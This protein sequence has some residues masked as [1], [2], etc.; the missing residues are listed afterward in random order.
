MTVYWDLS[1]FVLFWSLGLVMIYTVYWARTHRNNIARLSVM[2]CVLLWS[3]IATFRL[4]GINIGGA[5]AITYVNYYR[6]CLDKVVVAYDGHIEPLH[7]WINYAF[8][9]ITDDYHFCF[10][11]IYAFMAWTTCRFILCFSPS[12][13]NLVP[14]LLSIFLYWR[15]FN[16]IRSNLSIAFIMLGLPFVLKRKWIYA[17]AF[18]FASFFI[19]KAGIVF[20]CC[21]PFVQFFV[22]KTVSRK[23]IIAL[24]VI[25]LSVST[26]LRTLF[27]K[28]FTNVDLGGAYLSYAS[29]ALENGGFWDNA[30]KIAFEQMLLAT[31][32]LFCY[33]G[34]EK[35]MS[36]TSIYDDVLKTKII[37]LVCLYDFLLIP[38]NYMM[39]IW[40][41]YEFLYIPR[42][43]MWGIVLDI[44]TSK[45]VEKRFYWVANCVYLV[46]FT[47]W[48]SFRM[49]HMY[50]ESALMPYI[51]ELFQYLGV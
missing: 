49:Q 11:A 27:L 46:L 19:H 14:F 33:E 34:L 12:K 2:I 25:S 26:I 21:L 16:T 42:L 3:F 47:W 8:R 35:R 5:D 32:M 10:F 36:Q 48:L 38:L 24:I 51:F 6:T 30:W 41:G 18:T 20:A 44:I 7:A 4:I 43:V 1:S 9:V 45:I 13:I 15:G 50:E 40:R 28:F 17:Y 23:T 37:C 39:N 22:N 29:N 31:V